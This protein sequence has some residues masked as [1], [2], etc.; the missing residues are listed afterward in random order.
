MR[1][2]KKY[3]TKRNL[4]ER[5]RMITETPTPNV[6]SPAATLPEGQ[7]EGFLDLNSYLLPANPDSALLVK[8][9]EDS[10]DFRSGDLLVV[11]ISRTPETNQFVLI[12]DGDTRSIERYHGSENVF[13]VVTSVIRKL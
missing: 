10:E 6:P 3:K 8:I 7:I 13:G 5:I 11:D 12:E 4:P 9:D 1:A 2:G